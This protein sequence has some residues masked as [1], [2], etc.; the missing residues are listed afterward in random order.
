MVPNESLS[1]NIFYISVV[2]MSLSLYTEA[3]I[4]VALA[5]VSSLSLTVDR[6]S[7]DFLCQAMYIYD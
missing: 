6:N 3:S 5:V 1:S 4:Q 2:Y 7:D